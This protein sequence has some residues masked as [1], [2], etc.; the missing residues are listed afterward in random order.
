L[1]FPEL[2]F[3]NFVSLSIEETCG[4]LRDLEEMEENKKVHDEIIKKWTEFSSY[5]LRINARKI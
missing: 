4:T 5:P 1:K 2:S 3:V